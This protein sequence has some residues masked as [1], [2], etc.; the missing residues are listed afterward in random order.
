MIP[1]TDLTEQKLQE[2]RRRGLIRVRGL[3]KAAEPTLETGE[4][5]DLLGVTRESIRMRVHRHQLL[6]LSKSDGEV[7]PAFQFREGKVL[8][9]IPEVLRALDTDSAYTALSF[10]LSRNPDFANKTALNLLEAGETG[11][12]I[13]AA[14]GFLRHGT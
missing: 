1:N 3:R 2:A 14:R 12:V 13:A 5:C 4:V 9:G 8:R 11:T 6:D 10:L 7:F